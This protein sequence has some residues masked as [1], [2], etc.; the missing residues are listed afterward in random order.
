M[1][2]LESARRTREFKFNGRPA[3][4]HHASVVTRSGVTGNVKLATQTL[5]AGVEWGSRLRLNVLFPG[6]PLTLR[7]VLLKFTQKFSAP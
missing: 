5:V 4:L 6:K 7:R 3:M 2:G 1:I